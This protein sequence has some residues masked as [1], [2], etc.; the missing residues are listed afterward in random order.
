VINGTE[1]PVVE[2][3]ELPTGALRKVPGEI[4]VPQQRERFG[5]RVW[6]IHLNRERGGAYFG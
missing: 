4:A 3:L 1:L 5:A 2:K 6:F